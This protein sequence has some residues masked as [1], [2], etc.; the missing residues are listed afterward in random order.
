MSTGRFC[1]FSLAHCTEC[2]AVFIRRA[3]VPHDRWWLRLKFQLL[4][5]RDHAFIFVIVQLI[6]AFLCVLVNKFCGDELREMF[7]YEEHLYEFYTMAVLEIVLVGLL[8]GFFIAIICGQQINQSHYHILA[9][10]ELIKEYIVEDRDVN[11]DVV[12]LHPAM[13]TELRML[14]LY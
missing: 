13:L 11:K 6:V 7:G 5:T 12:E 14:G 10:Q 9:K 1:F 3:N 8:Y 4:V 2:R